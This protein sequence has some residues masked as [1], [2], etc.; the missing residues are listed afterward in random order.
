M[1]DTLA[2]VSA[3]RDQAAAAPATQHAKQSSKEM[4]LGSRL[5]LRPCGDQVST[6]RAT[7]RLGIWSHDW[8]L[9]VNHCWKVKVNV[10]RKLLLV[11][12]AKH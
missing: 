8:L 9:N 2:T 5:E 3:V 7:Q 6:I 12:V 11:I 1:I 4:R 10:N